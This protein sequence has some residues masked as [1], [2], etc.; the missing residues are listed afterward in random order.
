MAERQGT[1][2]NLSMLCDKII[3]AALLRRGIF[4]S[5]ATNGDACQ[6]GWAK[7][8]LTFLCDPRG[9]SCPVPSHIKKLLLPEGVDA[10]V[11]GTA[12]AARPKHRNNNK[13]LMPLFVE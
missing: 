4:G 8:P 3:E 12:A 7:C 1:V 9:C 10:M 5:L 13:P 2:S 11:K 6:Q